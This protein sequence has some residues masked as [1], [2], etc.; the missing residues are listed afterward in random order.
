MRYSKNT[1]NKKIG[2][3]YDMKTKLYYQE[4]LFQIL[5]ILFEILKLND[6]FYI[7]YFTQN[8]RTLLDI[9]KSDFET[10]YQEHSLP[11]IRIFFSKKVIYIEQDIFDT[12]NFNWKTYYLKPLYQILRI[13]S[14]LRALFKD[15]LNSKILR[16]VVN[17]KIRILN[18]YTDHNGK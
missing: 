16:Y 9:L 11:E 7:N 5:V 1:F 15:K 18:T 4:K 8:I 2:C 10:W 17:G 3:F 6:I 12:L 13:H 14:S